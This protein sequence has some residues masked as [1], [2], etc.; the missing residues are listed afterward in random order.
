[1]HPSS[2]HAKTIFKRKKNATDALKDATA[3][4]DLIGAHLYSRAGRLSKRGGRRDRHNDDDND[5]DDDYS[6]TS[7]LYET[8]W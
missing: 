7:S 2:A 8:R 5:A 1:M 4:N 6:D 3:L